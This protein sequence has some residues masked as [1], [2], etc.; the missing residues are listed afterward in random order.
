MHISSP[1]PAQLRVSALG[2]PSVSP[3]QSCLC[4]WCIANDREQ[5]DIH[6]IILLLRPSHYGRYLSGN[7]KI[8]FTLKFYF[9]VCEWQ[10]N[11][12]N[13]TL[14]LSYRIQATHSFSAADMLCVRKLQIEWQWTLLHIVNWTVLSAS[15]TSCGKLAS[16]LTSMPRPTPGHMVTWSLGHLVTWSVG[17]SVTQS[18]SH[19]VTWSLGHSVTRSL[20]Y[21]VTWSLGH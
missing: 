12:L 6:A 9:E 7:T 14:T 3:L 2:H 18:L 16:P 5:Y 8:L 11:W 4:D 17:H 1:S 15:F 20:G 21:L 19:L 13:A 10:L